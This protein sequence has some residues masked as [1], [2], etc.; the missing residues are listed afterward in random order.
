MKL[1]PDL[2]GP[3]ARARREGRSF[4]VEIKHQPQAPL[5]DADGT[6]R[7]KLTPYLPVLNACSSCTSHC[8]SLHVAVALPDVL[9]FC[10]TMAVPFYSGL[11]FAPVENPGHGFR[12][13]AD[14]LNKPPPEDWDGLAEI[15]LRRREGGQ[16]VNLLSIDDRSR[17]G[18]YG[19]RPSFCRTYPVA[20]TSE[21]ATGGPRNIQCPVPY[22]VDPEHE[23]QMVKDVED[24]ILRWEVHD[25]VVAEWNAREGGTSA[26]EFLQFCLPRTSELFGEPL[27]Y[28]LEDGTTLEKMYSGRIT[29]GLP[30]PPV[31]LTPFARLFKP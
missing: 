31:S 20:W 6:P 9:R 28:A 19:A 27:K 10:E 30:Q 2:T 7:S 25:D 17:C 26:L 23:A 24:A 5:C 11:C 1:H 15:Q 18:A 29:A 21:V 12:I 14:A 3:A 8:C 13:D 4:N 16:C 22:G